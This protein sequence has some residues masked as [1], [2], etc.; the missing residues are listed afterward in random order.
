MQT[1]WADIVQEMLRFPA[2]QVLSPSDVRC[3][4]YQNVIVK[5]RYQH[6][7][8][9]SSPIYYAQNP[10]EDIGSFIITKSVHSPTKVPL[11]SSLHIPWFP[12]YKFNR[13][14]CLKRSNFNGKCPRRCTWRAPSAE[15]SLIR[16]RRQFPARPRNP[17][18]DRTPGCR[19]KGPGSHPPR[20]NIVVFRAFSAPLLTCKPYGRN[21]HFSDACHALARHPSGP[22]F[23]RG[24]SPIRALCGAQI[25][26]GCLRPSGPWTCQTDPASGPRPQTHRQTH[27]VQI[28]SVDSLSA[29]M[30][31]NLH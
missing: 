5:M 4:R 16:Q 2:V 31:A 13:E 10:T 15:P 29:S 28:V 11:T 25:S 27:P 6:R 26:A 3:R 7:Q 23:G 17:L 14:K 20:A 9:F 30:Q 18:A 1:F 12:S 21:L 22:I 24:T 19:A 8:S